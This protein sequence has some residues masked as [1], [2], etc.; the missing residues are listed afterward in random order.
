MLYAINR[1]RS[2]GIR[3]RHVMEKV[4][5][6][7]TDNN[8]P[9]TESSGGNPDSWEIRVVNTPTSIISQ[10]L[11]KRLDGK[12]STGMIFRRKGKLISNLVSIYPD[13][14]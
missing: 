3:V 1:L 2:L 12:F 8:F 9:K 6:S 11:W 14:N 13:L 7:S 4:T 5:S 10:T